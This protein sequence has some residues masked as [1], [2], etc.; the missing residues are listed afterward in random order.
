LVISYVS[1]DLG[2][3]EVCGMKQEIVC[4][5]CKNKLRITFPNNNPYLEEH[6][7]FVDGFAKGNYVCDSCSAPIPKGKPCTAFSTWADYGG[8]PYYPWEKDFILIEEAQ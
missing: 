4:Q 2:N 1:A 5:K 6:V 3:R 8:I 7:K